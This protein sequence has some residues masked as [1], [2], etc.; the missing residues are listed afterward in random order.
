[1]YKVFKIYTL[2]YLNL[3]LKYELKFSFN[4]ESIESLKWSAVLSNSWWCG[5]D[6]IV[7]LSYK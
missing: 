5:N 2:K 4:T 3:K 6:N 7:N 1:M